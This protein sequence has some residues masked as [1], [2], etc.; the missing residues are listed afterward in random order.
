[1]KIEYKTGKFS[2]NF[3]IFGYI[4]L[5][6]GIWRIIVKDWMGILFLILS[7]IIIFFKS[8][9]II[10]ANKKILKKY[11][12]IFFIKKGKWDN[13]AQLKSIEIIKTTKSQTMS[14]LSIS[15]T[16]ISK[17][18]KMIIILP[19]KNIEIMSGTKEYIVSKAE[20]ISLLLQVP[21]KLK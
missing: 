18:Y 19:H 2:L 15:R 11:I 13:I 8:G 17:V 12:G 16:N 3:I 6:V 7:I 4:L 9:V 10:D 1:M 5:G 21:I 14:V 20:N